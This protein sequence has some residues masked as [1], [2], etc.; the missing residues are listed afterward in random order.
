[1]SMAGFVGSFAQITYDHEAHRQYVRRRVREIM[2]VGI[3]AYVEEAKNIIPAWSGA[4]RAALTQI[5]GFVGVPIFGPGPS[6]RVQNTTPQ[7]DAPD[8]TG[9]G[10]ASELFEPPV[11]D[12]SGRAFFRWKSNLFHL[13]INDA[14][15]VNLISSRF[16]LIN[17]GPYQLHLH[18][19]QAYK[20]AVSDE[21]ARFRPNT[22]QFI[23]VTRRNIG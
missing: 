6:S 1:M 11:V 8:R 19:S 4:S 16:R 23:K 17:P 20:Q 14:V 2:K 22:R 9:E 21:L 18:C 10:A 7:A 5:A 12:T 3:K 15:N 13:V